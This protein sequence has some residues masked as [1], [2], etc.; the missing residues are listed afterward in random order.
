MSI[1]DVI[2]F[3]QEKTSALCRGFP[4]YVLRILI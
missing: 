2:G 1:T 4:I 3:R